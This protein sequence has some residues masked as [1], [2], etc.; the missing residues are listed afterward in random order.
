[1]KVERSLFLNLV[2]GAKNPEEFSR[3]NIKMQLYNLEYIKII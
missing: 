2:M 3:S 1:V